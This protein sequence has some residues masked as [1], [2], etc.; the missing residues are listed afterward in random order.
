VPRRDRS[1]KAAARQLD[2][3]ECVHT[4]LAIQNGERVLEEPTDEDLPIRVLNEYYR[5][6]LEHN[7][8]ARWFMEHRDRFRKC[9][10]CEKRFLATTRATICARCEKAE[11]AEYMRGYRQRPEVKMRVR[12]K[13]PAR[14]KG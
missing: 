5:L 2:V 14:A 7:R 12:D 8:G 4:Y 3:P 13:K 10:T 9:R 1:H 6:A 11:K